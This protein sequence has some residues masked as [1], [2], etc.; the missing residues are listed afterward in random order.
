MYFKIKIVLFVCINVCGYMLYGDFIIE[1]LFGKIF[2]VFMYLVL[3]LF[4]FK[5]GCLGLWLGLGW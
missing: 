3:V 4:V 2:F 5:L 1:W